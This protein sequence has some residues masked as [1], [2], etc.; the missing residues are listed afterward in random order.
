M[1]RIAALAI[2]VAIT[3]FT[4]HALGAAKRS[5][6]GAFATS[7][8]LKFA[9]EKNRNG[10][11]VVNFRFEDFPLSCESGPETVAGGLT[12]AVRVRR[13][14]FDTVAI[15]QT[16]E[17]EVRAKLRLEGRLLGKAN[18][19]GSLKIAGRKVLVESRRREDCTSPNT[20]WTAA[21]ER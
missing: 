2:V 9:V 7:G 19:E 5:Y 8:T 21:R 10:K 6:A 12:Y 14:K 4:P 11:K 18:A 13:G 1:K 3:L 17:G 20:P 15:D 16:R